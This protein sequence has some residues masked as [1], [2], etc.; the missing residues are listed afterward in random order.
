ME[1]LPCKKSPRVSG[2]VMCVESQDLSY[3]VRLSA[4][5]EAVG[6]DTEDLFREAVVPEAVGAE[7][8]DVSGFHLDLVPLPRER[9]DKGEGEEGRKGGREAIQGESW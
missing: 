6:Y 5:A 2:A 4:V 7:D 1:P 3:L 9:G 8:D